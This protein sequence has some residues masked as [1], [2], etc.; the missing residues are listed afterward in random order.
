ME[1]GPRLG[2]VGA[3]EDPVG[4]KCRQ[5]SDACEHNPNDRFGWVV[6]VGRE[7]KLGGTGWVGRVEYLHYEFGTS[8]STNVVTTTTPGGSSAEK[9]DNQTINV[10]R[11]GLWCR[12]HEAIRSHHPSGRQAA[13]AV[14][15]HRRRA[16]GA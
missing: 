4:R 12:F 1:R 10:I 16:D 3:C 8:E 6:G 14:S 9:A 13:G 7:A 5:Q 15:H 11:A 2:A